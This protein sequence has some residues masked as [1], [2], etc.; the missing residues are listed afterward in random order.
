MPPAQNS[1]PR[2]PVPGGPT[3]VPASELAIARAIARRSGRPVFGVRD[4]VGSA[5]R[6]AA[7]PPDDVSRVAYLVDARGQVRYGPAG[8]AAPPPPGGALVRDAAAVAEPERRMVADA[9]LATGATLF[10]AETRGGAPDDGP[11]LTLEPPT[12]GSLRYAMRADG[13]LLVG[14]AA[15]AE[16]PRRVADP[17]WPAR[18]GAYLRQL[19]RLADRGAELAELPTVTARDWGRLERLIPEE[20]RR[21]ALAPGRV[22]GRP[23]A[24]VAAAV[25]AAVEAAREALRARAAAGTG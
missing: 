15:L 16:P 13:T 8:R 25:A 6:L 10:V 14:E 18:V 19:R 21:G 1:D 17:G 22:V 5:R 24:E 9:A 20:A 3:P 2:P 7:E 11:T 12:D 4:E 23:G